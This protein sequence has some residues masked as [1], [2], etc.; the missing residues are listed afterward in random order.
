MPRVP[1][2]LL[3]RLK[4][5][6]AIVR[7]VERAGVVLKG[8]GDN[9]LGLCPMHDDHEPSLVISAE[10]N[11]WHCLGACQAGGSVVDWVMKK[12]RV[13]FR[14]AVDLLLA[15]FFPLE[16][17]S[18][19]DGAPKLSTVPQLASPLDLEADE[20]ELAQIVADIAEPLE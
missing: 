17:R 14:H 9:L 12:D 13:S 20:Q 15:E 3:E 19:I 18:V 5:E 7:L 16:A 11:V 6:I 10:K 8:T 4:Q 1:N 2:E